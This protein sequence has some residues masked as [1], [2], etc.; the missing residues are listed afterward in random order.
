MMV[1]IDLS[2]DR[3]GGRSD[4]VYAALLHAHEGLDP[5]ASAALNARLILILTN[6]AGDPDAVIAA[7]A[8]AAKR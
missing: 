8:A 4:D 2:T 3:L 6:L 1:P 7:I 5:D